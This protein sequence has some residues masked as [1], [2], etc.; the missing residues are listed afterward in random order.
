MGQGAG[1]AAEA[2]RQ[3][4]GMILNGRLASGARLQEAVL[5]Q[6]L[7]MSRTPV[8]EAI[9]RIE[10][11]GLAVRC[12][13]FARVRLP[14]AAEVEE[15]FFLRIQLE[16]RAARRAASRVPGARLKAMAARLR[17]P[18]GHGRAVDDEFH[19]LVLD[20]AGSPALLGVVQGLR[21]RTSLFDGGQMPERH[22]NGLQ[23]HLAILAA[24]RDGNAEG[25][26]AAMTA[27]LAA[28]R[29]AILHRLS[30][31]TVPEDA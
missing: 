16:P 11:E 2:R 4:I 5:G 23:E 26:A 28:A 13:R 17:G 7:G 8:R 15:I 20:A 10:S 30:A 14:S 29:D 6:A 24:L 22:R 9:R 31:P 3:I 21:R 12:G 19:T 1:L 27:H 25:A 18:E